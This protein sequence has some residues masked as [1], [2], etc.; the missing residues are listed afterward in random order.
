MPAFLGGL[1]QPSAG[2]GAQNLGKRI[3]ERARLDEETTSASVTAYR[4]F[5]GEAEARFAPTL[6]CLAPFM[7]SPIVANSSRCDTGTMLLGAKAANML[8]PTRQGSSA[9]MNLCH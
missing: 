9:G 6:C 8:A 2:A 3:G 1:R 7:P 4:S 5:G